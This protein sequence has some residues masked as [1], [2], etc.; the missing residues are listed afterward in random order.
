MNDGGQA[1]PCLTPNDN[2]INYA[3]YVPGMTL[4]DYFAGQ[5]I[6]SLISVYADDMKTIARHA[7]KQA[8]AMIEERE[9]IPEWAKSDVLGEK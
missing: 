9:R 5:I 7:Y 4:R 6:G 1:F 3:D 2:N 8:D